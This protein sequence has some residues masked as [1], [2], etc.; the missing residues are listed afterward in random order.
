[1]FGTGPYASGVFGDLG[2]LDP[3]PIPQPIVI[4]INGADAGRVRWGSLTLHDVLGA[5]PNTATLTFAQ[6]VA[7]GAAVQI[8]YKYLT[9]ESLLFAGIVQAQTR[10]YASVPAI[11]WWPAALVDHT[12]LANRRRP[13][14]AYRAVSATT[15]AQQLIA[16]YAPDFSAAG[17]QAGL[18][19]VSIT[20]DGSAPLVSSLHA[21]AGLG[22]GRVKVDY[23]RVV[24]LYIPPEASVVPPDPV[25]LAHPPLNDPPITFE[26]DVSQGRT[27]GYG[28][29][30]GESV[31]T[32]VLA[33]ETVLPVADAVMFTS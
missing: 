29:G 5:Q 14:G 18:P 19:A 3:L 10:E 26:T 9:P 30:H 4:T 7:T 12:F 27:R 21:P 8:G 2:S 11:T 28:K 20:F 25:D 31:P 17:V 33:N 13:F 24:H 16:T 23:A 15:I 32:D 1:M 6:E 22:G